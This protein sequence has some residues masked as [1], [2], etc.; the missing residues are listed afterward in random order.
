[1]VGSDHPLL[2]PSLMTSDAGDETGQGR[3]PL[4]STRLC[5]HV[6]VSAC[7]KWY[8]VSYRLAWFEVRPYPSSIESF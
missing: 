7:I 1:M 4:M 6:T 5:M 8:L 3:H 2:K